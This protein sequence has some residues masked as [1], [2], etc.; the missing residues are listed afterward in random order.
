MSPLQLK[1]KFV[2]CMRSESFNGSQTKNLKSI[3]RTLMQS[4][5]SDLNPLPESL[6]FP[7]SES[8]SRV[9]HSSHYAPLFI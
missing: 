2:S 3:Q 4:M 5:F 1:K 7:L 6:F 8:L 9:Q